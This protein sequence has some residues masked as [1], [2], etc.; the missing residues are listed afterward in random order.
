MAALL[1][2]IESSNSSEENLPPEDLNWSIKA[3]KRRIVNE[4]VAKLLELMKETIAL[5]DIQAP[6]PWRRMSRLQKEVVDLTVWLRFNP[7]TSCAR[8]STR[9]GKGFRPQ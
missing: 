7:L 8:G 3:H 4:R 1:L 2:E 6:R 9:R 5:A